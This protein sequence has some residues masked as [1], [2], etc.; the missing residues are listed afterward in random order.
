MEQAEAGIH[1]I[2]DDLGEKRA[3]T[4]FGAVQQQ[5]EEGAAH[6]RALKIEMCS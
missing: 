1:G 4:E 2:R 6:V 5:V 3:R